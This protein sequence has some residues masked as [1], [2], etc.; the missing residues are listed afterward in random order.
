MKSNDR[1]A[2]RIQLSKIALASGNQSFS[3]VLAAQ[4][5]PLLQRLKQSAVG[6]AKTA[7]MSAA[8]KANLV[9]FDGGDAAVQKQTAA[10]L[11]KEAGVEIYRVDLSAVVSKYIGET[12]KNLDQLFKQAGKRAGVLY[13][14]EAEVLFGKRTTIKDANDKYA[15]QEV[16]YLLQCAEQHNGMII[17]ASGKKGHIDPAFLRRFQAVIA[18]PEN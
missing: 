8:Q 5:R 15:N 2:Q 14:D 9:L 6:N 13:F 12:E 10:Y 18:F 17:L 4:I 1:S 3:E 11:A 16:S 7:L